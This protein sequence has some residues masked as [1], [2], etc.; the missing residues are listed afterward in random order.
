MTSKTLI[1]AILSLAT[2]FA[3]NL[4]LQAQVQV[5]AQEEEGNFTTETI[6]VIPTV[7]T[8][9]TPND[10]NSSSNNTNVTADAQIRS[11]IGDILIEGGDLMFRLG[12]FVSACNDVISQEEPWDMN[13]TKKCGIVMND[14]NGHMQELFRNNSDIFD[15]ILYGIQP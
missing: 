12:D 5:Q 9:P 13:G 14:F 7:P 3:T 15:E 2:V 11:E 8:V 1:V 6:P 4:I 10:N